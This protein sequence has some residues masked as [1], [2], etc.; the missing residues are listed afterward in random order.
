MK[1][2]LLRKKLTNQSKLKEKK[3]KKKRV[4]I[5]ANLANYFLKSMLF[6]KKVKTKNFYL[7]Y[8]TKKFLK[9]NKLIYFK[10]L[11]FKNQKLKYLTKQNDTLFFK[12][13]TFFQILNKSDFYLI[14]KNLNFFYF[15]KMATNLGLINFFEKNYFTFLYFQ[16]TNFQIFREINFPILIRKQVIQQKLMSKKFNLSKFFQ[17][18]RKDF[19]FF[20]MFAL[21]KQKLNFYFN[22]KLK[23]L[24]QKRF[25]KKNLKKHILDKFKTNNNLIL[26]LTKRSPLTQEP[27]ISLRPYILINFSILYKKN[28]FLNKKNKKTYYKSFPKTFFKQIPNYFNQNLFYGLN[29]KN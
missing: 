12:F 1:H 25:K 19:N 16:V 7:N 23:K 13:Q 22:F 6:D 14:K 27:V 9:I 10:Y 3:N 24:I 18:F 29:E 26:N 8:K 21:S 15:L 11:K 2:F 4:R 28:Y 5:F 17:K 20:K